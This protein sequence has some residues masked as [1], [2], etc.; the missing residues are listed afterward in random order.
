[1]TNK[2]REDNI[3]TEMVT[4][5]AMEIKKGQLLDLEGDTYLDPDFKSAE[6]STRYIM[7]ESHAVAHTNYAVMITV[8]GAEHA[9]PTNHTFSV[10]K[11]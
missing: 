1:M 7:A 11:K 8:D 6:Y 4:V 9:F 5:D 10:V 3:V 2:F